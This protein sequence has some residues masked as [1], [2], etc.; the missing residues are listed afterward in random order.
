MFYHGLFWSACNL[1][2]FSTISKLLRTVT[3]KPLSLDEPAGPYWSLLSSRMYY[4]NH[5][6]H[7]RLMGG[8]WTRAKLRPPC[9]SLLSFQG[10]PSVRGG[11]TT[12][13]RSIICSKWMKN[14]L[15]T[16]LPKDTWLFPDAMYHFS[17]NLGHGQLVYQIPV[18][19]NR[20]GS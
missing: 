15:S 19:P 7:W 9:P 13:C 4:R 3:F 20:R 18:S 16:S 2:H 8:R 12:A 6:K 5:K 11:L 14:F 10:V 17:Q 1:I